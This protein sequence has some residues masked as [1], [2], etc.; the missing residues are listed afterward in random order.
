[1]ATT[2]ETESLHG[3]AVPEM[4]SRDINAEHEERLTAGQRAADTLAR[5]AGSWGFIITFGVVLVIWM[6]LNSLL[7]LFTHWDPYPFILL[8]LVLS[9]LAAVQAPVIMMS[10]NR[11]EARDRLKAEADY[12]INVKAE[13]E[14]MRLHKKLDRLNNE[15]VKEL[16]KLQ[17]EQMDIL[18]AL[19]ARNERG[20]Q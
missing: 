7:A 5:N 17:E 14:L 11:T 12:Q 4:V 9:C 2:P 20:P 10:Q 15:R 6:I 13:L 8:N 18:R 19:L 16:V 1:M 3:P